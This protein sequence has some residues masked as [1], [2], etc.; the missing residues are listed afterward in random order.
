M[1]DG[2][3]ILKSMMISAPNKGHTVDQ[4][5][6]IAASGSNVYVTWSTKQDRNSYASMQSQ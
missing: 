5:A 2:G 6:Q 3:K 1:I 4:N